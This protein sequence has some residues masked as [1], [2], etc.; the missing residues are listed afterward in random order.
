MT[1]SDWHFENSHWWQVGGQAGGGKTANKTGP[2]MRTGDKTRHWAREGEQRLEVR[3]QILGTVRK[4]RFWGMATPLGRLSSS[5]KC[6]YD[7]GSV[8]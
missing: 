1:C 5:L 8:P 6:I 7:L 3:G 2:V 4:Y